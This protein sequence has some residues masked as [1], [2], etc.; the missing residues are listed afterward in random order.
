MLPTFPQYFLSSTSELFTS[1]SAAA[2]LVWE[3]HFM[4][5]I[6]HVPL[7]QLQTEYTITAI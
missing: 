2:E 3:V 5:V 1:T 7:C 4:S 6:S